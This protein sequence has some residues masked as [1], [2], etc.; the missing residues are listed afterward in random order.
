MKGVTISRRPR[1]SRIALTL[2]NIVVVFLEVMNV[3]I[4]G[5][6]INLNPSVPGHYQ[7]ISMAG[8]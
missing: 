4:L 5:Y 6:D 2:A 8:I 3:E 7:T 1:A